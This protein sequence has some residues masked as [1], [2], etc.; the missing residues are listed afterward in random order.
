[1]RD[2]L[3]GLSEKQF[4]QKFSDRAFTWRGKKVLIRNLELFEED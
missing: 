3:E 2:E 1:M 4:K